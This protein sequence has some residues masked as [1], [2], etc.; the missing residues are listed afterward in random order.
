MWVKAV[1]MVLA[2]FGGAVAF[3]E[4]LPAEAF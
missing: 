3:P 2:L 4:A 1:N